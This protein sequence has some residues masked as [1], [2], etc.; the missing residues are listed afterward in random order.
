M[1]D[2]RVVIADD[3]LLVRAGFRVLVDT[4]PGLAVVGE[5]GTGGEA[6]ELARRERPDVV[7]M[8]VQMPDMDGIEATRRLVRESVE[9]DVKV[10]IL[11]T[12]DVDKYVFAAL[13]AG[14]SG[15]LLKDTPPADLLQAVRILAAGEALLAPTVTKRLI[16]EFA[17]RPTSA[18][19]VKQRLENV[20][21]REHEVLYLIGR[22]RSNAEIA[23]ALGLSHA[24]IKSHV[25]H[26]L[27]KLDARDR[28]QL[29]IT[30]YEAGLMAG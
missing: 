6:V 1:S 16:Q 15:F 20:T 11:T 7:L 12:F 3:Q 8:D 19:E 23:E 26:L 17:D 25:S 9:L 21:Q 10:L 28:I 30:A 4:A 18:V 14:A 29:V 27:A 2:I 24:T 5:A 13:R 22:G